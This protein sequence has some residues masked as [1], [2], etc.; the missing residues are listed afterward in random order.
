MRRS[1][2]VQ[3][4]PMKVLSK[5]DASRLL[6]VD[7]L[8]TLVSHLADRLPLVGGVYSIPRDS[9]AKTALSRLLA[10]LLLRTSNVCVYVS[11]WGVWPS[12]ENLELFYGYR[13]SKGETRHLMEAAAHIFEIGD[14]DELVSILCMV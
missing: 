10:Y 13:R 12:S 5:T 4:G 3:E 1:H 7:T 6:N 11:G 14:H 8:D 9:G 2:E